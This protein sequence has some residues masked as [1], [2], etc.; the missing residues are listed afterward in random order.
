MRGLPKFLTVATRP[1]FSTWAKP[2]NNLDN[3]ECRVSSVLFGLRDHPHSHFFPRSDLLLVPST[4][5]CSVVTTR[6][7]NPHS[8]K[9]LGFYS[10]SPTKEKHAHTLC[11]GSKSRRVRSN[12]AGRCCPSAVVLG[13]TERAGRGSRRP[14]SHPWNPSSRT[15]LV[16]VRPPRPV[17]DEQRGVGNAR[18]GQDDTGTMQRRQV[19]VSTRFPAAA[20]T[21]RMGKELHRR[22]CA[23]VCRCVVCM[24]VC[25]CE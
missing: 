4:L 11:Q 19:H 12:R 20:A 18:T 7:T 2:T 10:P 25:V 24:C 15:S 9:H 13:A 8:S 1:P 6:T 16:E 3:V 14:T 21:L 5:R 22:M 17:L 23:C